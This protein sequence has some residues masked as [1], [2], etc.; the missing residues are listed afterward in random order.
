MNWRGMVMR[1]GEHDAHTT[2][3]HFRQWCFLNK[4]LNCL[5]H[6]GHRETSA[7]GCQTGRTRSL[8]RL[9]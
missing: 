4:K 3:P 8:P 5:L 2:L 6:T 1:C 9:D 7:S